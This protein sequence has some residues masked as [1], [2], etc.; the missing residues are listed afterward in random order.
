[1]VVDL[2]YGWRRKRDSVLIIGIAFVAGWL[3]FGNAG[4]ALLGLWSLQFWPRSHGERV[5]IDPEIIRWGR[6]QSFRIT[7][8]EGCRVQAIFR[9]EISDR[10][11]AAICRLIK[12]EIR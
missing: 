9:G 5:V 11:Y 8:A 2:I 12:E 10:D 4:A 7:Y 1:M 3:V 6:L